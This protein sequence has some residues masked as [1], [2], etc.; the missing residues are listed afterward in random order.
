MCTPECQ[1]AIDRL[2]LV[3][4]RISMGE[5]MWCCDCGNFSTLRDNSLRNVEMMVECKRINRNM[6]MFCN[7]TCTDCNRKRPMGNKT[8]NSDITI[9]TLSI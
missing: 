9:F 5:N 4:K 7:M 3:S 1:R 2:A 8:H 6:N